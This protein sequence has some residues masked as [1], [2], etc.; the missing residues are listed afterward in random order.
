MQ[1]Q[2][3]F[4]RNVRAVREAKGWSQDSL[5]DATGLHRTYLSGIERG[6]RNPTLVV[7][8]KIATALQVSAA[9]LL[10]EK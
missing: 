2:T 7:V 4:G 1:I 5:A 10:E 3:K 8:Q 9:K 6:V